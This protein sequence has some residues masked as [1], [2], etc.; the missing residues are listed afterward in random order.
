MFAFFYFTGGAPINFLNNE[1]L[2]V[3][4]GG[5]HWINWLFFRHTPLFQFPIFENYNYGMELSSSIA[6]NDSLPI[7]ALI[8]KPFSSLLSVDFQYFGLWILICFILQGQF[9]LIL[10]RKITKNEAISFLGACFFIMAPPFLWRLWGH[11]SLMAHWLI[12]IGLIIFYSSNFKLRNWSILLVLTALVN[13][14]ILAIILSI[15]IIDLAYRAHIKDL[16][17]RDSL[18]SFIKGVGILISS[19]YAFGY[20]SNGMSIGSGGYSLYRANL[21]TFFNDN[22]LWSYIFPDIGSIP[23]DYEGFAFLGVGMICLLGVVIFELFKNKELLKSIFKKK[24]IFILSLSIVLFL[25]AVTNK[26]TLGSMVLFEFDLPEAF[27]AITRPLRSSGRMVWLLFYL[28]YSLVFFVIARSK[29]VRVYIFILPFLL[30]LQVLDSGLIASTFRSKISDTRTYWTKPYITSKVQANIDI[31][32]TLNSFWDSPLVSSEWGVLK[33]NYKKIIYVYPKNRPK[34]AY[35]LVH[36][37]ANNRLSTNFGYFSRYKGSKKEQIYG[38][39][40]RILETNT[41]DVNSIYVFD[42]LLDDKWLLALN[43]CLPSDLCKPLDG[44]RIFAKDFYLK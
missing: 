31:V 19:L 21:N 8:F 7:M 36:F 18:F 13:A 20:F 3:G 33:D 10:L 29:Y 12:I 35:P 41:F 25:F 34:G 6:I 15:F 24:N 40:D 22:K 16:K 23:N 30:F 37:A 43:K 14:Y 11:Y 44:Y 26:V 39:L 42:N 28:I 32:K 1:W 4:D 9:A 27:K 2:R 38:D 17:I 5:W